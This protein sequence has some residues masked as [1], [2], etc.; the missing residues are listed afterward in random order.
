MT[1]EDPDGDR[2]FEIRRG[3][4][5]EDFE[6]GRRFDHHWGRTLTEYDGI[7]FSTLTH[8]YN[9]I[10]FNVEYAR[11]VG[12]PQIPINPVFVA[13]IIMGLSVEDLTESGGPFLGIDKMRFHRSVYPG[14][15]L[16]ASSTVIARRPSN[17]RR[18][19]G[20][21]TWHSEGRNQDRE[22]VIDYERTNFSKMRQADGGAG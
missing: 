15:T 21:V 13:D 3:F 9:P 19:W 10:Y 1:R 20:I 14:D 6:I 5:Y 22:L 18:G 4:H 17:S 12:Y 11:H 7:L 2:L 16:Y 8:S